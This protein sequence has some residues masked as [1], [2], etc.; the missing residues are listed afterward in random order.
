MMDIPVSTRYGWSCTLQ[1]PGSIG[2]T[3]LQVMGRLDT[4]ANELGILSDEGYKRHRAETASL[5]GNLTA[6]KPMTELSLALCRLREHVIF[7][8]ARPNQ[9]Q[10]GALENAAQVLI[11][12]FALASEDP[13]IAKAYRQLHEQMSLPGITAMGMTDSLLEFV[14]R[15]PAFHRSNSD[16]IVELVMALGSQAKTFGFEDDEDV[17]SFFQEVDLALS[18]AVRPTDFVAITEMLNDFESTLTARIVNQADVPVLNAYLVDVLNGIS[19]ARSA[20][21]EMAVDDVAELDQIAATLATCE[22]TREE[23]SNALHNIRKMTIQ[24]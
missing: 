5:I 9:G 6:G 4:F 1:Q 23:C 19:D 22:M 14:S 12:T 2:E 17:I 18:G 3:A 20:G 8:A 16:T 10:V 21:M 11:R 7:H 15:V 13:D 24:N